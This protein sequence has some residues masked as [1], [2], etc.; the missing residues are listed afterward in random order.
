MTW[1][2]TPN[3]L[4]SPGDLIPSTCIRPS[5]LLKHAFVL[6]FSSPTVSCRGAGRDTPEG[7]P[8]PVVCFVSRDLHCISSPAFTLSSSNRCPNEARVACLVSPWR[9]RTCRAR[10]Y[11][12]CGRTGAKQRRWGVTGWWTCWTPRHKTRTPAHVMRRR[13]SPLCSAGR[14]L[15]G[16]RAR[17]VP[18]DFQSRRPGEPR[19]DLVRHALRAEAS[20]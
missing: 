3:S 8:K 2:M 12:R 4:F 9:P 16:A 15:R 11:R 20:A 7:K 17:V 1:V 5:L 6:K 14:A 19:R 13:P 18:R 10:R